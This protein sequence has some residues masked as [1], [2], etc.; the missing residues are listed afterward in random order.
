[1]HIKSVVTSL[2]KSPLVILAIAALP[3]C[4]TDGDGELTQSVIPS[5]LTVSYDLDETG[6]TSTATWNSGDTTQLSG[7]AGVNCPDNVGSERLVV[8][9][10]ASREPS[11]NLDNFIAR[12][13]ATCR[14]YVA[15]DPLPYGVAFPTTDD[16]LVVYTEPHNTP[17]AST[18]V[19]IGGNGVNVPTGVRLK[20]NE[21]DGYVKD[22]KLLYRVAA[23]T[24]L[25]S[26]VQETAY[27][28]GLSGT[29]RPRMECPT[30][31]AL[32][33]IKVNHSLNSGKIRNFRIECNRLVH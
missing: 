12:L 25:T 27:I 9:L 19:V 20:V 1:M 28:T 33:G 18:E 26:A 4:A 6:G 29:E 7:F 17:G 31:Y 24:G 21:L 16:T 22:V 5:A 23:S 30:D 8:K 14:K 3:A 11:S 15:D 10:T 13:T 2:A 32:T